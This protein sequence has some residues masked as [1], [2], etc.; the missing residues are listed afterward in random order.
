MKSCLILQKLTHALAAI[1]TSHEH[2]NQQLLTMD[3]YFSFLKIKLV[4]SR[5]KLVS[6]R[7]IPGSP[8]LP[9]L[10]NRILGTRTP[11]QHHFNPKM[12]S[13]CSSRYT[14]TEQ[15]QQAFLSQNGNFGIFFYKILKNV[16]FSST[17]FHI[18]S[19][20][21]RNC[22]RQ[23]YFFLLQ[24]IEDEKNLLFQHEKNLPH[25]QL[26]KSQFNLKHFHQSV[27]S[28]EQRKAP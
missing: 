13:F 24:M 20:N 16:E 3:N 12:D 18:V 1:H 23:L 14:C 5:I 27:Y 7:L 2:L 15:R 8:N 11:S 25:F 17:L 21:S 4:S 26:F 10:V 22:S 28:N 19:R 6:S 9:L